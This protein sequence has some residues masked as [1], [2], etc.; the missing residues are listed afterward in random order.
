MGVPDMLVAPVPDSVE[1]WQAAYMTLS[2]IAMHAV[3]QADPQIGDRVVVIGQGLIGLLVTAILRASGTRVMAVD[4][5]ESRRSFAEAMGAERVVIAGHEKL[6]DAARQWTEGVGA[7]IALVCTAGRN[8]TPI[9]QAAEVLRDRGRLVVVGIVTVELPQ[10]ICYEKELEVRY[11]RAYGPGRYD[12]AYEWGGLDYPVGYVRW[13]EQRNF[14]ACLHLMASDQLDVGALTSRRVP[15]A[16]SLKVYEQMLSGGSGD[17]GVVLEYAAEVQQ[18]ESARPVERPAALASK[19]AE[20]RL[21]SPVTRLDV[22]GAGN[23]ARTMLLPHL[24]GKIALGTVM[25]QTSLSANHVKEKFGFK[26]AATDEGAIFTQCDPA[27]VLIATRHY[28]HAPLVLKA[29]EAGR[30]VF[31]EKPLCLSREELAMIDAA[32]AKSTGTVIVGFNRR[33]AP[34]TVELKR[35]L[36]TVSGAMSATYRVCA[37]PLDPRHWYANYAESGGRVVGEACH[38]LDY[39]C[40]LF[41]ARPTR[42]TAHSIAANNARPPFPDSV[43]VQVEFADGSC[44]QLLYSAEA[45]PSFPKE[46]LTVLGPGIV[47]EITNFQKLSVH[48]NRKVRTLSFS[49]KGHAEEIEAWL[50]FLRAEGPHPLPYEQARQSMSL[51]FAALESIQKSCAIEL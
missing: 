11:S 12:A 31:V 26:S 33:F 39:F 3:R 41:D 37:G 16:D 2:A 8:N 51:T 15:F 24:Q 49:S 34:A 32:V 48:Q 47:A 43:A 5:V 38:F 45:D 6:A 29:L 28:L 1:N 13:T 40:F 35:E 42:V 20:Q 4:V 10:K 23:F 17:I 14:Q 19:S 30:Q 7:D 50:A 9:E 25:N 18:S 27:A 21:A 22:I 36:A 44:G 46:M